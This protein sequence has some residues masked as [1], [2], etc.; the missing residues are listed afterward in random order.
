MRDKNSPLSNTVIIRFIKWAP[1]ILGFN[2]MEKDKIVDCIHREQ[3]KMLH[4]KQPEGIDA[5]ITAF[6]TVGKGGDQC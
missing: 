4:L 2:N 3:I 6:N 5:S 1:R